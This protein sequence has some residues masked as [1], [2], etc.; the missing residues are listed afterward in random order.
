[1]THLASHHAFGLLGG[2]RVLV[3]ESR[4]LPLVDLAF[5]F[6]SGS[7]LDPVGMEGLARLMARLL[8]SG[9]RG[10]SPAKIE[11]ELAD[12]GARMSIQVGQS[13]LTLH[14]SVLSRNLEPLIAMVASIL[15]E[16]GFRPKDLARE[17]RATLAR[18]TQLVDEDRALAGRHLYRM[19]YPDHPY[20]RGMLGT[21]RSVR[22]IQREHLRELWRRTF[23]SRNLVV[24]VAGDVS[25]EDIS[26]MLHAHLGELPRQARPTVKIPGIPRV[27]GRRA[28]VVHKPERSQSQL[29]VGTLGTHYRDPQLYPLMLANTAFGETFSS[30]LVDRIRK[31][32]GFSYGV[33]SRLSLGQKRGLFSI[34]SFPSSEDAIDCLR[35]ELEL[36]D[37]WVERGCPAAGL[38]FA[39]GYLVGARGMELDTAEKRLDQRFGPALAGLPESYWDDYIPR[40]RAVTKSEADAAVRARIRPEDVAIS[41]V[42]D[43]DKLVPALKQLLGTDDVTRHAPDEA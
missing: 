5:G 18:I 19:L 13:S 37:A 28:R 32:E 38:R 30:P 2:A 17:R 40:L 25:A 15:L 3:E 43:A 7:L 39:K 36:L 31:Q 10:S 34:S 26:R 24:G 21:R 14:A 9:P 20:G 22:S 29:L 11:D 12:L 27:R 23:T 41:I 1:M 6:R 4:D 35:I 8:R 42:G 16:P 33:G